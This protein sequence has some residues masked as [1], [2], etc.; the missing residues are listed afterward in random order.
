M[1]VQ[2]LQGPPWN[3]DEDGHRIAL[4]CDYEPGGT[5]VR[6]VPFCEVCH[7]VMLPPARMSGGTADWLMR[8]VVEPA[9]R[10][11]EAPPEAYEGLYE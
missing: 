10:A 9:R 11:K 5:D 2:I 1:P 7:L 8:K 4:R 6:I 3:C